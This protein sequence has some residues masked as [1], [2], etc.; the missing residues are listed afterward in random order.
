MSAH[1]PEQRPILAAMW[2]SGSIV[3]FTAMAIAGRE[4]KGLHDTFEI[5]AYRSVIGF[6]LVVASAAIMGRLSEISAKRLPGHLL[7]NVVHFTGQNLW[8]WA[9]TVIPLAQVFALEFTSPLWVILLAPLFLGEQFTKTRFLAALIGFVGILT[10]ARPDFGAL[11]AGVLAA[12]G[13]AVCFA[14]TGIL[15]K[16]LTRAESI[17]SILFWLTA[18]QIVFGFTLALSDGTIRAPSAQ[19]LPSLALI[20]VCGIVAHLCL[21]SAL[22]LAPASFVMPIDFLRLPLIAL[23]GAAIYDEPIEAPVLIGGGLI[24]VANLLHVRAEARRK[25]RTDQ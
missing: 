24:L 13:S 9:V 14:V 7:R 8:F 2:M 22:R 18:M 1:P 5:M 11:D 4:L 17:V 19:T 12:A 20:G 16:R 10:V 23:V 6:L 3:S 25:T 21:T 15:T